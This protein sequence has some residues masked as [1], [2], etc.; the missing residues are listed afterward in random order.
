MFKRSKK[1]SAPFNA[2][3]RIEDKVG[4][5][6]VTH[7][8]PEPT[9][10]SGQTFT[11]QTVKTNKV[12]LNSQV[13]NNHNKIGILIMVFGSI[14]VISL[15]YF[16]YVY[17][18]K[19]YVIK[20]EAPANTKIEEKKATTTIKKIEE[21][22]VVPET[23]STSNPVI[24]TSSAE[25]SS[26]TETVLPEETPVISAPV[27]VSTIDTDADGLTDDEEKIVGTDPA[28]ADTDNDGYLDLAELKSG[29]DPLV[30]GKK[31]SENSIMTSALIDSKLSVIYPNSWDLTRSDSNQTVVFT[32]SDKAFIQVV[33]EDNLSKM[34]PISWFSEQFMGLSP[35]EAV[36]G[37]KWQGIYSQDG[38]AA[39]IF[40][41]D[42]SKVYSF[43]CSPLTADT[44][45][46]TLFH[47]MI[48]TLVI[49]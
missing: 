15:I 41:S 10:F 4:S 20:S 44:S 48:K 37:P 36:S 39:Y 43:S 40:N 30:P 18:V 2:D 23:I 47:L 25:T 35:G 8:M 38:L 46:V 7:N 32:D 9:R 31:T 13:N 24:S 27:K 28:K 33:Y 19:P 16:G 22:I 45:S 5:D 42:L 6:F 21:P 49:K 12:P 11:S 14:L 3:K 29:Y 1:P 17:F 34:S 26:T